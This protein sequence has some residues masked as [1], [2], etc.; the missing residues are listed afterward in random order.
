[1]VIVGDSSGCR[2]MV[3]DVEWSETM[4]SGCIRWYFGI[5]RDG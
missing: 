1:M 3:V 2:W 4:S 5:D